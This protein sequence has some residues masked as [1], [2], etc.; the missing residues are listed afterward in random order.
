MRTQGV[1]VRGGRRICSFALGLFLAACG[2]AGGGGD[3]VPVSA[4]ALLAGDMGGRGTTD[5]TGVAARFNFPTGMATDSAGNIYVADADSH[6]IRKITPAGVVSTLAGAAGF[7]GSDDSTF[8]ATAT[9]NTP[10][11][12]AIDSA[13]NVYVADTHN[14]TIRKITLTPNVMVSTVLAPIAAYYT[15]TVMPRMKGTTAGCMM[16]L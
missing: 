9:F 3:A 8:G 16:K 7:A 2:G 6:T 15:H 1:S 10:S 13:G 14:H 4:L 12:V 5:G 11:G